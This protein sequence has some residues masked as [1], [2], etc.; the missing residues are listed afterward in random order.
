ML[1]PGIAAAVAAG[2]EHVVVA[3]VIGREGMAERKLA[4]MLACEAETLPFVR[5]I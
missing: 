5:I 2:R 1:V 4:D 3:K